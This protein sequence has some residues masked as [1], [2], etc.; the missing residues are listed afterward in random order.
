M[1]KL[2][3][4]RIDFLAKFN[5]LSRNLRKINFQADDEKDGDIKDSKTLLYVINPVLQH[6]ALQGITLVSVSALVPLW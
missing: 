5:L 6:S 1:I 4:K 3:K 2:G